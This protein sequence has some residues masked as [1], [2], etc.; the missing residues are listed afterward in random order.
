MRSRSIAAISLFAAILVAGQ[1]RGQDAAVRIAA[2]DEIARTVRV[3]IA[4]DQKSRYRARVEFTDADGR[5]VSR[6]VEGE[7]CEEA[8]DGIALITALAIDARA[9]ASETQPGAL[10]A[11]PGSR[12]AVEASA[13]TRAASQPA[14][15][16]QP[17][18]LYWDVGIGLLVTSAAAPEALFGIAG[19]VGLGL[20]RAGPS[21]R[22]LAFHAPSTGVDLGAER[23][24]FQL[25]YGRAEACPVSILI[26][27][28]FATEPCVAMDAGRVVG[29]GEESAQ[30]T[31]PETAN[32]LWLSL[33]ALGRLR[34]NLDQ[35]LLFELHGELGAPLWPE[36]FLIRNKEVYEMPA[37]RFGGGVGLGFRFQ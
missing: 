24:T 30:I 20:G 3:T 5:K 10:E 29:R 28:R 32:V 17:A 22:L 14:R 6:E 16:A 31:K 4:L 35:F 26:S 13:T 7:N 12:P 9:K 36:T 25:S 2:P 1:A 33:T 18:A 23:A 37:V 8:A 15:A 34:F 11:K 21:F 27:D 19:F